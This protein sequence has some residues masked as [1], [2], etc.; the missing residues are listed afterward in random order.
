MPTTWG[1][2]KQGLPHVAPS[3]EASESTYRG[4]DLRDSVMIDK[5]GRAQWPIPN[6][7]GSYFDARL[8]CSKTC[9]RHAKRRARHIVQAEFIA[10]H[11]RRRIAAM[12]TADANL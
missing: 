8:C 12:F 10:E 2:L 1:K 7:E 4:D 3:A 9:D 11:N 6:L 5:Y